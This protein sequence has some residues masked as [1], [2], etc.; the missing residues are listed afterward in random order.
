MANEN[1]RPT[2][3]LR[4]HLRRI[5]DQ[6][7]TPS[8]AALTNP[9]PGLQEGAIEIQREANDPAD[10]TRACD[11]AP[12]SMCARPSSAGRSS[13]TIFNPKTGQTVTIEPKPRT[14]T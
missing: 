9:V 11:Q 8:E 2:E 1:V 4:D 6:H 12:I 10:A 7:A 14:T 3:R 13:M 5:L